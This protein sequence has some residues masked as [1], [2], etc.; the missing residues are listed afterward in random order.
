KHSP[1]WLNFKYFQKQIMRRKMAGFA[2]VD[3]VATIVGLSFI[4][5]C[6]VP[7]SGTRQRATRSMLCL[8]N[9]RQLTAAWNQYATDHDERFVQN[10][11]GA[12]AIGGQGL[13]PGA[14]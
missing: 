3:V 7:A 10:F 6:A 1:I 8:A 5:F 2:R 12:A 13:P 9:M 14:A 11:E 4:A